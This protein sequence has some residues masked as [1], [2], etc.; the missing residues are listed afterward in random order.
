[1]KGMEKISE[2]IIDKV[3]AD[4]ENII[5]R[6]KAGAQEEIEKAKKQREAKL[7]EERN[8]LI[9]EARKEAAR[10]QAQ[11]SVK[12][13]QELST[14]KAGVID[15]IIAAVKKTLSASSQNES[16]MLKLM[17]E[18][19][20]ILDVAKSRVYVSHKDVSTVQKL[21]KENK[22]LAD[23][24]VEIKETECMGG[25]AVES[26]DGRIRIDNTYEARL[27]MLLPRLLPGI[28]KE[29]FQGL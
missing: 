12:V 4:A 17:R 8:R 9:E 18:A 27:E 25:I 2:A 1:M 16:S 7:E 28:S 3:R 24:I 15:E 10:V 5:E 11:A 23:K 19:V 21:L 6:A 26:I 20:G 22:E 29:L 14:A 13:H